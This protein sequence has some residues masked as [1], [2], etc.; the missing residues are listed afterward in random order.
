MKSIVLVV[1]GCAL[2]V[3]GCHHHDR[4]E[5]RDTALSSGIP[6]STPAPSH[7]ASGPVQVDADGLDKI[8]NCRE[9]GSLHMSSEADA[10]IGLTYQDGS[11]CT[12]KP[13]DDANNTVDIIFQ[14][15]GRP[16]T[17]TVCVTPEEIHKWMV[18]RFQQVKMPQGFNMKFIV[19]GETVQAGATAADAR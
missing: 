11:T 6:S 17:L 19:D 9:A 14:G 16:K 5:A 1:A 18:R 2:A 15:T 7:A 12:I 8:V 3:T 4:F 13:H 10:G